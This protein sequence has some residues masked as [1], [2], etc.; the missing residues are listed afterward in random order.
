MKKGERMVTVKGLNKPEVKDAFKLI[1]NYIIKQ[2]LKDRPMEYEELCGYLNAI[3][4]VYLN[5][6]ESEEMFEFDKE[7][8]VL[9]EK[10]ESGKVIVLPAE[11]GKTLISKGEKKQ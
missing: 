5:L 1:F 8:T 7:I 9:L 2:R 3:G 11:K 4:D 6:T 10:L